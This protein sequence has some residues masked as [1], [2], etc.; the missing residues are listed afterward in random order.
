MVETGQPIIVIGSP[1]GREGTVAK[2]IVSKV[3]DIPNFGKVF[4]ILPLFPK[5]RAEPCS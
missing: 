4:S 2:G 3:K 1:L 5:D